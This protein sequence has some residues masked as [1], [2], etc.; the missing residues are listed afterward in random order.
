MHKDGF[1]KIP[2]LL[3]RVDESGGMTKFILHSN[4]SSI[5]GNTKMSFMIISQYKAC[6]KKRKLAYKFIVCAN[7]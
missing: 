5:L 7:D 4:I 6:L 2:G 3:K 1:S